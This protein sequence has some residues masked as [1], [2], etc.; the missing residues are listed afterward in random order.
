MPCI[1]ADRMFIFTTKQASQHVDCED[2]V[3]SQIR[4][5]SEGF[6]NEEIAERRARWRMFSNKLGFHLDES[7]S[8]LK[9]I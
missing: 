1:S 4:L 9:W 8:M 3:G 6:D 7:I 5:E 2:F